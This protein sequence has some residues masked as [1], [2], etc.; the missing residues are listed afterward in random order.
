MET[1]A[2][3]T[4]KLMLFKNPAADSRTLNRIVYSNRTDA[5]NQTLIDWSAFTC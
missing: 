5:E 4:V 1:R 2:C 3:H